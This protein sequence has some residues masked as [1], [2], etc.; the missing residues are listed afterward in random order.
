MNLFEIATRKAIRF[1]SIK[2]ELSTEQLWQLPLTSKVGVDLDTLAKGINKE[3]KSTE[4]ESFVATNSNPRRNDLQVK[5][6]ILK[7][8][9]GVKQEEIAAATKR[10]AN[11]MERQKLQELL[12]RKND[13]ALEALTP[14]QIA[15]KLAALDAE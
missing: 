5:L 13:Q 1:P 6:D 14:E 10:Q 9:I 2:G 15:A 8:I 11:A 4:E 3:L 7:H 12:A